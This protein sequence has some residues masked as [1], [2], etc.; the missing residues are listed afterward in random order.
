[1]ERTAGKA[2]VHVGDNLYTDLDY[3]DDVVLMAEQTEML[4]SALVELHQTEL[5]TLVCTYH[6]KKLRY[7][8]WVQA[9]GITVAGNTVEAVTELQYLG[10]IQSSSGR[11][12]FHMYFHMSCQRQ[13]LVVKWQDHMKNIDIAVM[14]SLPNIAIIISKRR[15]TP[16]GHVVRLDVTTPAHQALSQVIG[17]K[18]GH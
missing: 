4:R 18:A 14:T 5:S 16:F 2:G 10:S 12:Y 8:N 11:C 6:G 13:I 9:A 7:R 15:H 3:A 17:M 1:M